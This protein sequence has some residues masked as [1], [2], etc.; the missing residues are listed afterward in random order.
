MRIADIRGI[1]V[2]ARIASLLSIG[3][4]TA[5]PWDSTKAKPAA[6]IQA[7]AGTAQNG[8]VN[9]PVPKAP[10][11]RV[12]DAEGGGVAGVHITWTVTTGGG[13][14]ASASSTTD[15]GGFASVNTWTLG[16][17]A[18]TN[19][20]SAAADGLEKSA[21]FLAIA[22]AGAPAAMSIN[23]GN[24]QTSAASSAVAIAPSVRV[25]DAFD[26]AVSGATVSFTATTGGGSVTGGIKPSGN[27][28]VATVGS[29]IL[30]PTP[31]ANV[32]TAMAEGVATPV[33]FSATA[34]KPATKLGVNI[35]PGG[36]I[37]EEAFD[38]QPVVSI[39]DEDGVT[40]TTSSGTV[41]ASI[42]SG[43]GT[44]S[45]TTTVAAV[46]GVA[47]FQN[48][49]V[50]GTS[51]VTL[52]FSSNGLTSVTSASFTPGPTPPL[53]LT[54]A[55]VHLNQA[56]QS[57][58]G[59][60][61]IVAGRKA[62]ARVFVKANITNSTT[63]TVRLRTFRNGTLFKEY[64]ITNGSIA[65]PRIIDETVLNRSWNVLIPE[66][67]VVTGMSL[68]ADV[69]PGNTITE[70]SEDDNSY[71]TALDVRQI[72]T[73]KVT[74]VP[75][76]QS[77]GTVGNITN[78]NKFDVID[79]ARRV[80]PIDTF[81]IQVH[82]QY[83]YSQTM[84]GSAYDNTWVTL[85]N[86]ISAM[87]VAE[88]T[89]RYYYGVAHPTYGSGG[90]GL[91]QIGSPTAIGMDFQG[92]VSPGTNYYNMT[93]AHEWG[94]NFGRQHINCGGPANPDG[95]Y[96]YGSDQAST[97]GTNGYDL[98]F[99]VLRKA[100]EFKELMSYCQPVWTSDYT[101]KAVMDFRA[102]KFGP[103][104]ASQSALLIWGRI[105]PNGVVL[106]PSYEIQA[107]ISLPTE[108]GPYT[109]QALDESGRSMFAVSFAGTQLDH[110]SDTRTFAYAVPLPASG[111]RPATLRLL[112]GTR[113]LARRSRAIIAAGAATT[114]QV[115]TSRLVQLNANRSR[116]EWDAKTYPG[117]MVRDPVTGEVLAFLS[118]GSAELGLAR[119]VD[120][121][122]STGVTSV[123]QRLHLVPR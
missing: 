17:I 35:Q 67:E 20:L 104:G 100:T 33:N 10:T 46:N 108:S 13:S 75:V 116:L 29:W 48:L 80:Y 23:G 109:V 87:R 57:Y 96:P 112:S 54:I 28:G 7:T 55:N 40:V 18:G 64:T 95:N 98:Q 77:T 52:N 6:D 110:V 14:V 113:E 45:G 61:P 76:L 3:L 59:T 39:R 93:M 16:K 119:E 73:M 5:C 99:S 69:D 26:N 32:L 103:P 66:D 38:I 44:L 89:D 21:I 91:G 53:N 50:T 111:A 68:A 83:N 34:T 12:L 19:T 121:V 74:F 4:L 22:Q 92:T 51:P 86:Q 1:R 63:P 79:F 15:A 27:G 56:T 71:T 97:V 118:G 8:T 94:H 42:A 62:L 105:G 31:G 60:V 88:S 47:T 81:D 90:T 9:L 107:P 65:P 114:S 36:A 120:V 78:D 122:F 25:V 117:A 106:E 101:Y 72:S 24:G 84:S 2:A 102:A 85:L 30:G 115:P 37:T 70:S 11:V 49:A 82:A 58:A 123:K 41:T 43:T